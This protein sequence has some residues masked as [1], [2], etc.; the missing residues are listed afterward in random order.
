MP[1]VPFFVTR[2]SCEG[3][4]RF[5]PTVPT[6]RYDHHALEIPAPLP[7][8]SDHFRVHQCPANPDPRKEW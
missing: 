4:P 6:D 2:S 3:S 5:R 8:V 1:W 7:R